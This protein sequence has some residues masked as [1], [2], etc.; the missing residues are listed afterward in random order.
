MTRM[1]NDRYFISEL[2]VNMIELFPDDPENL[3]NILEI[4]RNNS[5][6]KALE[7][8]PCSGCGSMLPDNQGC[9]EMHHCIQYYQW[10]VISLQREEDAQEATT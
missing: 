8:N 5:V 10:R 9:P 7:K 2:Q 1:L 4:V 3:R 6:P